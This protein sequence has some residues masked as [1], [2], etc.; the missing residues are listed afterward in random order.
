MEG[1]RALSMKKREE[2]T[3]VK[4]TMRCDAHARPGYEY[5]NKPRRVGGLTR[6]VP[7]ARGLG[8]AAHTR[9]GREAWGRGA[10]G[11]AFQDPALEMQ[12]TS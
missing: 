10:T 3:W 9:R 4:E 2:R 7:R 8:S 11:A 12:R 1:R 6:W 5:A